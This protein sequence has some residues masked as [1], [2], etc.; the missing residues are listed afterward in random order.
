MLS[1]HTRTLAIFLAALLLPPIVRAQQTGPTSD[2]AIPSAPAASPAQTNPSP[3]ASHNEKLFLKNGSY[4]LVRE[5]KTDGDRIRYFDLDSDAWEEM[6]ASLVDWNATNQEAAR[7]KQRDAA[8]LNEAEKEQREQNAWPM[9]IDASVQIA[10]NVFLPYGNGLF[11]FDGSHIRK[12]AQIAP[13]GSISKGNTIE[14]VLVPI[15]IVPR[16]HSI[17]IPGPRAAFRMNVG[18]PE[19]Y[20]RTTE[21]DQPEL[22][23][24]QARVEKGKRLIENLNE[25]FD[26]RSESRH[27]V[28]IHIME[29]AKGLFR[30]TVEQNLPPGEYAVLEVLRGADGQAAESRG[31]MNL[32]VWDFGLD[33]AAPARTA[34]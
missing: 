3:P 29:M 1:P 27:S 13:K 9:D 12:M 24:V 4:L 19:F 23:L 5:Y 31:E 30:V 34:K 17:F 26:Q 20:L 14:R 15:P 16:R 11:A 10:P 28:S 6:P 21:P 32:Y 22:D 8:I 25:I 2:P 33:T 7:E 18:E